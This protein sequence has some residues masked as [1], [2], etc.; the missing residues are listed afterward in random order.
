MA[1]M[2]GRFLLLAA[3]CC[4]SSHP[5]TAGV[6]ITIER[7]WLVPPRHVYVLAIGIDRYPDTIPVHPLKGSVND[8]RAIAAGFQRQFNGP[9]EN[10][11]VLENAAAT[12]DSIRRAL[13]KWA[14][15]AGAE[16]MFA[17]SFSGYAFT[18][19]I[20]GRH[21]HY[22]IPVDARA[23]AGCPALGFE[24]LDKESLI[25]VSLFYSWMTQIRAKRQII[26]LDSNSTDQAI[27]VFEER[28]RKEACE[29]GPQSMKRILM[30]T[31]HGWGTE[32]PFAGVVQGTLT[33]MALDALRP[34]SDEGLVTSFGVQQSIY[35]AWE[36]ERGPLRLDYSESGDHRSEQVRVELIGGD[37]VVNGPPGRKA[38][39]QKLLLDSGLG[40]VC[41]SHYA[42]T[43]RG[44]GTSAEENTGQAA[45]ENAAPKS[46]ALVVV[47]CSPFSEQVRV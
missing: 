18:T 9:P 44:F 12:K 47:T 33:R 27:P 36:Q 11:L 39:P 40:P 26:V 30:L 1:C 5:A 24:C 25:S 10:V 34:T 28:W 32:T 45:P 43:G 41:Y 6:Q 37:F 7:D 29:V 38:N 13:Q 31:N 8:A 23:G 4:A 16:D 3:L 20:P 2:G 14:I 15:S 35:R 21:E 19:E 46:Y 22:L 17:L 42:T